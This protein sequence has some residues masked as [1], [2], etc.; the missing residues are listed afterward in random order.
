VVPVGSVLKPVT[1]YLQQRQPAI[2]GLVQK[3]QHLLGGVPL[4]ALGAAKL[5]E[6]REI[7]LAIAELAIAVTLIA[8]FVIELRRTMRGAGHSHHKLAAIGWFDLAA[9][10]MLILEAFESPH[11]KPGYLRPQF[12]NG[13][14]VLLLALFEHR[15][16]AR[17]A[18]KRYVTIDDRGVDCRRS[19]FSRFTIPWVE[20]RSVSTSSSEVVFTRTDGRVHRLN[21]RMLYNGDELRKAVAGEPRISALMAP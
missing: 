20:L 3:I 21:L 13:M 18:H 15:L 2:V 1:V 11:K 8:G 4:L 6:G 10:A 5:R 7:P 17:R 16:H 14:A 12:L 19:R 9:G